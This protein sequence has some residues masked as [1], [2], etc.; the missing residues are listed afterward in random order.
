M[1][2]YKKTSEL[3]VSERC[4]RLLLLKC[5]SYLQGGKKIRNMLTLHKLKSGTSI[6]EVDIQI[7][8]VF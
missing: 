5:Q 2:D 7:G 8:E 3:E 1:A 4:L 6:D